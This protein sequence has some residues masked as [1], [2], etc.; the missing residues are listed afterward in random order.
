MPNNN[1]D[2]SHSSANKL[3]TCPKCNTIIA[4]NLKDDHILSHEIEDAG[5]RHNNPHRLIINNERRLPRFLIRLHNHINNDGLNN[6]NGNNNNKRVVRV[7]F[8]IPNIN[9]INKHPLKFPEITIEDINKLEDTNKKCMIC[10]EDFKSKEKVS[11]LPCIHFFHPNC[12]K[13]WVE[14]K[15]ECPVCKFVL[16]RENLYKKMKNI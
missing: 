5:K 12:I 11:A 15:N 1:N 8:A 16:T 14:R 10:L 4:E 7:I 9:N 2:F 13:E 3:Y 6:R